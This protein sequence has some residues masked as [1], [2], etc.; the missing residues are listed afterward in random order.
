MD[1]GH[2][3]VELLQLFADSQEF[4]HKILLLIDGGITFA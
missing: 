2:S 3:R 1:Q 4:I